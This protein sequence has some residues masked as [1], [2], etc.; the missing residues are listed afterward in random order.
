MTKNTSVNCGK[1]ATTLYNNNQINDNTYSYIMQVH[2]DGNKAKHEDMP[3]GVPYLKDAVN[4]LFDNNQIGEPLK[5]YLLDI[6]RK[7]TEAKHHF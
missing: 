4:Q 7:G 3:A 5:K 1:T 2:D 6:N